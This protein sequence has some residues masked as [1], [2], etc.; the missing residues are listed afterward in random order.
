LSPVVTFDEAIASA[1]DKPHLLLGNGFSRACRNDIFAYDSLFNRADFSNLSEFARSSFELLRTTDFEV[2]MRSLRSAALLT[3]AYRSDLS[4]VAEEFDSAAAK[5]RDVLVGAIAGHHPEFPA[6]ISTASYA[7]CRRFLSNFHDVYTLNYDLLLYWALMQEEI[8][9]PVPH[10][11][12]FR[13]PEEGPAE[14][15]SWEIE[16]SNSQN[17]FYLHGALHIF[18]TPTEL[19]KYTWCNTGVRLIE[20]IR[21]AL[22]ENYYP[23]FVAEGESEQK[24]NRIRHSDYLSRCYRSFASLQ[25]CL[26]IYGH[27]LADNDEH[28]LYALERGKVRSLFVSLYGDP[29]STDN[30]RIRARAE[31][32]A[33]L[34]RPN[35][36]L[37][38]QFYQA[39]SARVWAST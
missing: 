20:Q 24:Y 2:V 10:D 12:G 26:F 39:E 27:S 9:P 5:L 32:I 31:R 4:Q 34:R 16:K 8:E 28:I 18:D 33:S 6:E 13:T 1:L 11:D 7:S 15:V 23:L 22:A 21:T 38:V 25:K 3:R 19:V 37:N 36:S 17:V 29:E 35:R 14:Y 30:M